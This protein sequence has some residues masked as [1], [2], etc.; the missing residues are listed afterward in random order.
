MD[1]FWSNAKTAARK[2]FVGMAF[3]YIYD[4]VRNISLNHKYG[5]LMTSY[6]QSFTLTYGI[7]L[8][9][10]MSADYLAERISL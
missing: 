7:E 1:F 6:I 10:V 8:C 2:S 3:A 9:S 5:V 4:I